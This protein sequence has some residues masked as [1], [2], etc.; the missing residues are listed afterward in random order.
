[1]RLLFAAMAALCL[2]ACGPL[3]TAM[4]PPAP[5]PLARTTIDDTALQTAWRSFDVALDAI[6]LLTDRGVIVPGTPQARSIAAA[7]RTVNRALGA[8]ERFAAAG[9]AADYATALREATAGIAQIREAL[10]GGNGSR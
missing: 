3:L 7:I 6:N 2:S 4:A 9:S 10:G 5:A 8:A 1:M